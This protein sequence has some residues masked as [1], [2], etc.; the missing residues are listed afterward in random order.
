MMRID[1][2]A[3]AVSFLNRRDQISTSPS[4]RAVDAP[5]GRRT[6]NIT[7]IIINITIK[8]NYEANWL[9]FL[10]QIIKALPIIIPEQ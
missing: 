5:R 2:C 6:D 10:L 1:L 9:S 4:S 7:Y 3:V 8:D